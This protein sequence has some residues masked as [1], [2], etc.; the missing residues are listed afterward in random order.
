MMNESE[1]DLQAS[2]SAI[3]LIA[4]D[5]EPI[6]EA[7]AYIVEDSGYVPLLASNGRQAL[8]LA[9]AF[10][11]A[12]VITDLMMPQM[13]GAQLV[14]ALRAE[15][16]RSGEKAPAIVIMSAAGPKYT[17]HLGAD[18]VLSKPF[19]LSDVEALL[20]AHLGDSAADDSVRVR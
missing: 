8:E 14:A 9:R 15:A 7:L 4:E 16:D 5:E 1:R 13:T 3:V 17:D 18:A 20:A 6:A 12:L 10:H 2:G 11:P 19:D